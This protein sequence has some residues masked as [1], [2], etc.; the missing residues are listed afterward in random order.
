M[1][2]FGRKTVFVFCQILTG[3]TCIIAAFINNDAAKIALTLAG[4]FTK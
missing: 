2:G 3:T 1:D 4:I